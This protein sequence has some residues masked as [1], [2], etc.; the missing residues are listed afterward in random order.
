[1]KHVTRSSRKGGIRVEESAVPQPGARELLVRNACSLVSAGTERAAL[2]FDEKSLVAKARS[3]PD[4]VRKVVDRARREGARTALTAA[5]SK[6]DE[7]R[8]LGYSCAGT[9]ETAGSDITAGTL[10]PGLRVACSGANYANHAEIVSVPASLCTR[11]PDG[12]SFDSACYVTVASIALHGVRLGIPTLGE[13]AAVIGCGLIGQI[14]AQIL[15]AHGVKVL[16]IDTVEEKVELA[17]KFGAAAGAVSGKDDVAAAVA[18]LT[19]GFGVDFVLVCAATASS[20]PVALAAEISRDRGRVISI[21]AT[22]LDLPRRPFYEKELS[23]FIS[24][25]YG[26]G[27]YD[28]IYEEASIDYPI[29]YVRWTEGRNFEAVLELI[30]RGALDVRSLTTHRFPVE[31]ASEAYDLIRSG[32]EPFLGVLID[33][34]EEEDDHEDA[35]VL[36]AGRAKV[37]PKRDASI[38]VLGAGSFAR[39]VLLPAF[40]KEGADFRAIASSSGL[41][42]SDLGRRFGFA[43]IGTGETVLADDAASIAILTRHDSHAALVVEALERGKSVFVEKPLALEVEQLDGVRRA[44]EQAQGILMVGFNR[45]FAP[46]SVKVRE[47]FSDISEPLVMNVRVNAGMVPR[48]HWIQDEEIGG[49]RIIGEGCHFIDWMTYVCGSKP[50]EIHAIAVDARRADF[51][52]RDQSIITI[53]FESGAIG[54]LTYAARGDTRLPKEYYEVFAGERAAVLEDFQKLTTYRSGKKTLA[55]KGSQ[56]KGHREEVAAFLRAVRNGSDPPIPYEEIFAV[57]QATF[58]AEESLRAGVPVRF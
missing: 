23:F 6:L 31:R 30:S 40:Q 1:M 10:R 18:S 28:P 34:R 32:R 22:G 50:T 46:A 19:D 35:I 53:R 27:R 52:N 38:S 44:L 36:D 49:G 14:A 5:F 57:T 42:A 2:E 55:W 8:P 41:S 45:R 15:T 16:A 20:D 26:P 21:G 25:S 56:A 3:R 7:V 12:V 17:R 11:I 29:G 37:A 47:F 13:R 58:A 39:S 43:R 54:S 33:Y 51:P 24:R 4:L 9:V 48:G